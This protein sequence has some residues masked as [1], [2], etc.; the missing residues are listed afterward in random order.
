MYTA[1]LIEHFTSPRNA[2][3]IVDADG[4]GT[5][6][7]PDCGDYVRLY[8]R[9]RANRL[10]K[11]A[12]EIRGCPASIATTSILT[13]LAG[14]KTLDEALAITDADVLGALGGLPEAKVHCSNLGTAALRLAVVDYLQRCK[15]NARSR[16]GQAANR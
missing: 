7:D 14:G 4:V 16:H 15:K 6:G 9:V 2:G 5:V 8:I 10:R 3:K 12:F 13:E 1:Q 11:V